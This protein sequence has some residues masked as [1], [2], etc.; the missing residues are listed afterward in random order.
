MKKFSLTTAL[1]ASALV[2][3]APAAEAS[4]ITAQDIASLKH[5]AQKALGPVPSNA[6]G[7]TAQVTNREMPPAP[8]CVRVKRHNTAHGALNRWRC[9]SGTI[10]QLG[11]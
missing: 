9:P 6:L 3:S 2:F 1:M 5:I 7:Y 8:G 11:W 10:K 4:K